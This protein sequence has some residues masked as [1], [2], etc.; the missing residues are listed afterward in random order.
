[1]SLIVPESPKPD[2]I[3]LIDGDI[4]CYSYA[5]ACQKTIYTM[6]YEGEK[7]F[8]GKRELNFFLSN[9]DLSFE[10]S[11]LEITSRIEVE[12]VEN[13]LHSVNLLIKKCM[14]ATGADD[15]QVYLTG[16]DNYRDNYAVTA[17]YKGHR[18]KKKPILYP[19]IKKFLKERHGAITASGEEADDL[20][21]IHQYTSSIPTVICSL[22][23]DLDM[24]PGMHYNWNKDL[25]YTITPEEG[26]K[27]FYKQLLTGDSTDN[28]IGLWKVGPKKA[29]KILSGLSEEC[30]LA[31][32]VMVQYVR[33][34]DDKAQDRMLENGILLWMRSKSNEIWS[35]P[36]CQK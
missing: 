17:P 10:D 22:D 26:I 1:M 9:N 19:D 15:Y 20:L 21:S 27:N 29:E 11:E 32:A 35:I 33:E 31:E 2:K 34:F 7:T 23:K 13:A 8:M 14:E 5:F 28:I 12:P 30:E 16:S 6:Q 25:Y 18:A 36:K 24:V 3:A 4:I